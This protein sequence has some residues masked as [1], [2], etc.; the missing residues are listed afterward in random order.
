ESVRYFSLRLMGKR[1]PKKRLV[2]EL[3]HDRTMV[4]AKDVGV[5]PRIDKAR[6]EP[7]RREEVVDAPADVALPHLGHVRPPRIGVRAVRIQVAER[8]EEA[9]AEQARHLLA[10][11][12]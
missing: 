12:V 2:R 3:Q 11:L 1:L 4:A 9:C 5:D 8:V 10:F 7:L 6:S